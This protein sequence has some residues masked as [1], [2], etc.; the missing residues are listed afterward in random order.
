M[1]RT[2]RR[3]CVPNIHSYKK[4][5]KSYQP[6]VTI[7]ELSRISKMKIPETFEDARIE[8]KVIQI[9]LATHLSR[10][11]RSD[12]SLDNSDRH[13]AEFYTYTEN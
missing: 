8:R 13:P 4:T 6:S 3:K 2:R 7:I 10:I 5:T 11:S 12:H 1:K 9:P